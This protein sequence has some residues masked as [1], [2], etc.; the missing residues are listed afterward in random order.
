M[1]VDS[2]ERKIEE[3]NETEIRSQFITPAILDAGWNLAQ[4]VREEYKVAAGRIDVRGNRAIRQRPTKADYVL[5]LKPNIPLAV[6]EAKDAT[7]SVGSGMQQALGYAERLNAPFVFSSNG[8]GFVFHD[9]TGN[10]DPRERE[11]SLDE[12]PSPEELQARYEAWINV[13]DEMLE[14]VEQ[15]F[16]LEAGKELRWYQIAA[17][18]QAVTA[19][20]RGQDRVLL[21]M[22]TGT[23]KTLTAFQIAWR[24]WKSKRCKRILFLADRNILIDQAR[25]NDFKPFGKHMVQLKGHQTD[26][27]YEIYLSLYQAISG[28]EDAR[29]VYKE[30]SPDFFDLVVVD[31]CHRGSAAED[32][33]WREILD[34]FSSAVHLGMTATPKETKDV[35]NI[36]YFGDPVFTYSLKEGIEDG[37]LA[38]YKVIRI[39]LDKDLQGWRPEQGQVDKHG[40]EIPDQIYDYKHFDD[41]L[42]LEQRTRLVAEKVT[43]FLQGTDRMAKTIVFCKNQDHAERMRKELVNLNSDLVAQYPRYVMRITAD[44]QEGKKYLDDFINPESPTPVIATTS[45]LLSTGVDAQTCKLIV[46]DQRI[47]SMTK[48]KQIIGRGTRVREDYDKL[49]FTIM[50]FR[51]ATEL[52]ADPDF[53]GEPVVI[54]EPT[55]GDPVVPPDEPPVEPGGVDDPTGGG[56]TGD[57]PPWLPPVPDP[58]TPRKKYYVDDVPVY[59]TASRV[60]YLSPDGKLITESIQD[61]TRKRVLSDFETLDD[62]LKYWHEAERKQAIV[63]ELAHNGVIF[64]ALS[65]DVGKDYAAFDLICHVAFD[66]PPLTR[67]QR[68]ANVRNSGY[69]ATYSDTARKVLDA[70]LDKYSD[71]GVEPDADA[72]ILRVTPFAQMGTPVELVQEFGG[73]DAYEQAVRKLEEHLYAAA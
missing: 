5:F 31:E 9:K 53:D 49:F 1:I 72:T 32:A 56:G 3:L 61:Y 55:P 17:V 63:D 30:F 25:L 20:A 14:I 73:R 62:F 4:Q 47:A 36:A 43:E 11:I 21:V 6:V 35:S 24:L 18:N 13:E 42:V 46:L 70:L 26:P 39:D 66:Q 44:D 23:G 65:D 48:F 8:R 68:A 59:V 67:R 45:E 33:A 16:H 27:S 64:E 52:F 7:H 29:N 50:D 57:D 12:F 15:D 71:E 37:Y 40:E 22:A 60:Q 51:K 41:E 2:V 38:P 19:V 54:Y 58:K 34:Y 28:T 69:F 10:S